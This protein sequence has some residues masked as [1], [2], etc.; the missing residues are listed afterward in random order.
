MCWNRTAQR[1]GLSTFRRS[2]DA[3]LVDAPH[4]AGGADNVAP[5][6]FV[7]SDDEPAEFAAASVTVLIEPL[8]KIAAV[9][10][11]MTGFDGES[12]VGPGD[13]EV[14]RLAVLESERILAHW[15]GKP[16]TVELRQEV[17][18]QSRLGRSGGSLASLQP[19]FHRR[20]AVLPSAPVAF[21]VVRGSGGIDE[22][23]MPGVLSGA[24]ESELIERG[25]H[26]EQH[27]KR[28]CHAQL[29]GAH[30]D[31]RL[32]VPTRTVGFDP[33]R[34]S[35]L[36]GRRPRVV[37]G[38]AWHPPEAGESAGGP[39]ADETHS[40]GGRAASPCTS[41]RTSGDRMPFEPR[42]VRCGPGFRRLDSA[43]TST[44]TNRVRRSAGDD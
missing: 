35:D 11:R 23:E 24:L 20:H 42:L 34:E 31:V 37:H 14:D 30:H 19:A 40:V 29:I 4:L 3:P 26:P 32:V 1:A 12:N 33:F 15:R 10:P 28:R 27:A 41:T 43:R 44:S 13:V 25:R 16:D 7:E 39:R 2:A 17:L 5:H 18:L 6:R 36:Q 21:E 38:Q 8:P 22:A 9:P